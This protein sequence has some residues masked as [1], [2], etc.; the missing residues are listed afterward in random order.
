M[1]EDLRR[2]P[3]TIYALIALRFLLELALMAAFV[4]A[5][6]R[7]ID[8]I[9]GWLVGLLLLLAVTAVWGIALSP[10]RRVSLPVAAR[11]V[12]ELALFVTA[13]IL[14]AA[15]GLVVLGVALLVVELVDLGLLQGPDKHA[16]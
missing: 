2:P 3:G 6:V 14:L 9:L 10:K 8:G 15:S 11:V 13:A 16:L 4:T 5:A 12:I 1:T 7:L